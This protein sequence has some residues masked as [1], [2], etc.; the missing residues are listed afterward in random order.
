MDCLN[1]GG[2][3]INQNLNYDNIL[4]ALVLLFAGTFTNWPYRMALFIDARG[5]NLEPKYEYGQYWRIF[6]ML[7]TVTFSFFLINVFVGS[8][9]S[10]FNE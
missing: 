2:E 9:V 8:V 6:F 5:I 10:A 4:N 1:S 3:W 7:Y